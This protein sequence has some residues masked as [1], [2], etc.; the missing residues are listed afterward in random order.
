MKKY[1][2]VDVLIAVV[3]CIIFP[4]MIPVAIGLVLWMMY[5]AVTKDKKLEGP[6][7]HEV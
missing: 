5:A 2:W 6:K 7:D 4:V 1:D 3:V